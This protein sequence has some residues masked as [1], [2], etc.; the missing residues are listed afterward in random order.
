MKVGSLV[1]CINNLNHYTNQPLIRGEIY[2]VRG[3][4]G[5]GSK[6]I[7]LEGIYNDIFM[8]AEVSYDIGRFREIKFP[9]NME[10]E[11]KECLTKEIEL[12]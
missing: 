9:P 12:V 10:A 7:Y 2:I 6:G 8:G 1:E 11:I 4:D 3:F 5:H